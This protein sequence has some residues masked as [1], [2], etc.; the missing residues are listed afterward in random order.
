MEQNPPSSSR[1]LFVGLAAV[2]G[3]I[4]VIGVAAFVI[5]G[6]SKKETPENSATASEQVASKDEVEQNLNDLSS[7][8]KQASKD[9]AAAKAALKDGSSQVKVGN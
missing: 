6:S 7:T 8:I 3:L 1:L 5:F 4:V 9:Q 2:V